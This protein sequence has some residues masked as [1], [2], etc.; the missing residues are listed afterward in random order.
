MTKRDPNAEWDDS[1]HWRMGCSGRTWSA[2]CAAVFAMRRAP[3]LGQKPRRL[4]L[5]AEEL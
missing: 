1:T 5:N 2:R 4:P 3:Q